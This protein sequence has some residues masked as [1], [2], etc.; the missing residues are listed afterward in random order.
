MAAAKRPFDPVRDRSSTPPS[1]TL[2]NTDCLSVHE[3][4]MLPEADEQELVHPNNPLPDKMVLVKCGPGGPAAGTATET[5]QPSMPRIP[6]DIITSKPPQEII[7]DFGDFM[8]KLQIVDVH[9]L[10]A[11]L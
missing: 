3:L 1:A 10:E 2:V 11:F 5:A 7:K 4:A 6:G 8:S 9:S